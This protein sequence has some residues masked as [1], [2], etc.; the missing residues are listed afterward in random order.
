MNIYTDNYHYRRTW[1]CRNYILPIASNTL[2]TAECIGGGV[3]KAELFR[4]FLSPEN[5][6][7]LYKKG[8]KGET[9][10]ACMSY[11][12][13]RTGELDSLVGNN[14]SVAGWVDHVRNLR[15]MQFIVLRDGQ[16]QIQI[17]NERDGNPLE[18]RLLNLKPESTVCASGELVANPHVKLGGKELRLHDLIVYT[19]PHEAMPLEADSALDLRLDYRWIDLRTPRNQLMMRVQTTAE[20]AMRTYWLEH[21]FTEIHSPKLMAGASESGAELFTLDYFGTTASLAQ[22]PQF[23][24]QMAMAAGIDRVFEIGPVFRANKSHTRRHDTEFTSVD[25]EMAWIA[26]HEDIMAFEESWLQYVIGEVRAK[27]GD[28]IQ[29]HF[30]VDIA[31]PTTPFPRVTLQQAH[32]ILAAQGYTISDPEHNDLDPEG[33]RRLY[34]HI[35]TTLDHDFVFVTDYPTSVRPF[36][37]MR[38]DHNPK[39]TKSFDLLWKGLE[40]TT[41]AQREYRHDRLVQQVIEKGIEPEAVHTYLDFFKYGVPPHGGFGFGLSR[42]LMNLLEVQ[43]V[44]E[45]TYLPRDP[46]RLNP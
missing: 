44:R 10:R 19:E 36:Y 6:L 5:S 38:H 3:Y 9:I 39:L 2:L 26:S 4:S 41:G 22:S 13:A 32:S 7:L 42:M 43:N 21:G 14:V 35:K 31:V 23:Y 17:T 25:V 28:A 12:R 16:G 30:G 15:R 29:Q 46:N 1:W 27:H 24:K 11:L 37:H 18:E 8:Y 45:V 33:E 20:H 40:V 34:Q